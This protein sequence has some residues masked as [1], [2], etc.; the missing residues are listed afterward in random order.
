MSKKTHKPARDA[1]KQ[2]RKQGMELAKRDSQY[3]RDG[4]QKAV[5]AFADAVGEMGT[6]AKAGVVGAGSGVAPGSPMGAGAQGSSWGGGLNANLI[7][8]VSNKL[9]AQFNT[10]PEEVN[11]ALADAGLSWSP[12]FGPGRPLDPFNAYRGQPRDFN[13]TVG[14]NVQI[15]PRWNRVSFPT[16]K[17]IY[18]AYDVAQI[19]VRHLINDVR[20]LDY[21]WVPAKNVKVDISGDIQ[22]AQEFFEAPDGKQPFHNWLAEWM[23]DILRYD[24][25]ALYNRRTNGLDPFAL[26][27][28]DGTTIIPLIDYYGRPPMDPDEDD[29][30][31]NQSDGKMVVPAYTQIIQ[32]MPW[33]WLTL[34]DM[35]YIPWNPLPD[36]QYGL[37]P[38]E[39]VLLSANTDIR[40]QWHFLQFFTQGT[41]PAGFM[42]A[43]ADMSDPAQL[44]DWEN[45]WNAI[46]LGDQAKLRQIRWVPNGAKFTAAKASADQFNSE[47]PLYLMRRTCASFG[48][49][50]NDLGF[51]ENVNRATGD[52]QI[53]VQFRVGTRPL[54]RHIEGVLN[55]FISRQL[56]LR[57]RLQFDDG[58]ETEDRVATAQA[59]K[60]YIEAG[61]EGVDE[62]RQELG[63]QVDKER[64]IPRFINNQRTGPIPLL[65]L[66]SMAG[67]VDPDTFGPSDS[68]ELVSTPYI[69]PPGPVPQVG[70]PESKAAEMTSAQTAR[71]MIEA[72]TGQAPPEA[73]PPAP[74]PSADPSTAPAIADPAA[75]ASAPDALS[76]DAP[77]TGTVKS[78]WREVLALIDKYEA[79]KELEKEAATVGVTVAT[80]VQGSDLLG[81]E[82]DE[83]EDEVTKMELS[84]NLRRWKKH[85]RNAV[86]NGRRPRK[87]LDI[88]PSVSAEIYPAIEKALTVQ[89]VDAAFRD[90][91]RI[92][93]EP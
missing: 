8:Q 2:N 47:F 40:F 82:D 15:T 50:P 21:D 11:Q 65:A 13:Y 34:D 43:P 28:V 38:L 67:E 54:L 39:A 22:A 89:E 18:E 85:A 44:A 48:V 64:P 53:D 27:V 10:S 51:T 56:G 66:M 3:N 41:L 36:S 17:A 73:P 76:S 32:G 19:C 6:V 62:V 20:S 42:E 92:I 14:E 4:L 78:D 91:E 60:I 71:D 61:V 63:L 72:T 25:G 59:H 24:A 12:P 45:N 84:L 70:T 33:D 57:C 46:M 37:A 83:I 55:L 86:K 29:N 5:R 69:A 26:E 16:I 52:T 77:P 90:W 75:G 74:T 81:D 31:F 79:K 87:F 80:G 58:R 9:G 7:Q 49:T 30:E 35:L 68:Q 93:R 23:Q 1:V 88:P